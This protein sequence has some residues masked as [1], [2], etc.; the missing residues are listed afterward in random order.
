MEN[1]ENVKSTTIWLVEN[2]CTGNII[3]GLIYKIMANKNNLPFLIL[4]I[5]QDLG[6][7][8]R[9]LADEQY[10]DIERQYVLSASLQL[11]SCKS[12]L[13]L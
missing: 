11:G 7:D 4:Q 9:T 5:L 13:L 3:V 6:H 12:L 2:Y 1:L 10:V 8:L